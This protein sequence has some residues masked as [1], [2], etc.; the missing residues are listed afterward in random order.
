MIHVQLMQEIH[1]IYKEQW[2]LANKMACQM[3]SSINE[4]KFCIEGE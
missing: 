1:E 2:A 4:K 3:M